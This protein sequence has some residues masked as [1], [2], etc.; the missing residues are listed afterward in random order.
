MCDQGPWED[1]SLYIMG[2]ALTHCQ[3]SPGVSCTNIL[4][5]SES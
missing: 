5:N 3:V 1:G 4:L 2:T